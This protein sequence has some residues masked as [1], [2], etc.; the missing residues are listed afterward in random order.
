MYPAVHIGA[1]VTTPRRR[2]RRVGWQERGIALPA[3]AS[4]RAFGRFSGF[5]DVASDSVKLAQTRLNEFAVADASILG[6]PQIIL[7]VDGIDGEQTSQRTSQFQRAHGLPDSGDLDAFTM[8]ALGVGVVS[9]SLGPVTGGAQGQK[10]G[11]SWSDFLARLAVSPVTMPAQ[12]VQ[13]IT[14]ALRGADAATLAAAKAAANGT[15]D[16]AK[17]ALKLLSDNGDLFAKIALG[18]GVGLG[19]AYAIALGGGGFILIMLLKK[20]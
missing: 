13:N 16:A 9:S 17:A 18:L 8:Q 2:R 19:T 14:T 15:G 3:Q 4:A 12:G 1:I 5:G 11:E 6:E 7:I 20:R 10:P